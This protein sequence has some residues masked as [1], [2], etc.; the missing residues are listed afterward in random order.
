MRLSLARSLSFALIAAAFPSCGAR[1]G[2]EPS[3]EPCAAAGATRSCTNAC[4]EGQQVCR[5]GL[6]QECSVAIVQRACTNAC[7]TGTQTCAAGAWARCD[8]PLASRPCRD[9][10]GSG[11]EQ[12]RDGAW[13]PCEVPRISIACQSVCGAGEEVCERGRWRA[14]SAPQPL[15]PVLVTTLRDFSDAHPD[16]ERPIVGNG[17]DRG[18]V[19]S[20]LGPDDKPVYSNKFASTTTSGRANFDQWYRDVPGVNQSAPLDLALAPSTEQPGFFVYRNTSFFPIDGQLLGNEGRS[21]NYHFTLEART[22]FTY[23]GGE[24][25]EFVGDDDMW[26]FINRRLAMDLGGLHSPQ[27]ASVNLDDRAESL[28]IE[29]GGT[30]ALHF[31]FAERKTVQ[32]NFTIETTIAEPGSCP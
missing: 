18:L 21:H 14:C 16:F 15:P 22:T 11:S 24:V 3:E 31:F 25:F 32:S 8:V 5:D 4:G 29:R 17:D 2:L 20:E 9:D 7:G 6:W 13:E 26:V 23:L 10:C 1:T 19:E 27:A 30:Y 28:G 12:C